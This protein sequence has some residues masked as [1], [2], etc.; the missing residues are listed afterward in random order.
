MRMD[1]RAHIIV[2]AAFLAVIV[3]PGLIQTVSE[4]RDGEPPGALDIFLQAPT[5]RNLHAYEQGLEETSLVIKRFR[6]WM[7]YVQW[8]FLA[9]AGEKVVV[10]RHGWLFYRPSVLYVI[11][12]RTGAPESDSADPLTA[13]RSFR[14]QLRARGIRL[15]VVPVPNKECVYPGMLAKRAEG[16]GVVVCEPTRRLLDQLEQ[17]GIEHVDLFEVFRRAKR[18]ENQSDPRRLYLAQDTHWS[19][20]GARVAA[21]A[22]ARRVLDGGTVNRG[23][24]AYVEHS[25]T[26]RRHGD[27]VQMLQ[28]PRIE[29]TLEPESLA[30]LRVVQSDTGTPYHDAPE[31]AILILGDSFLRIYERD[32]PGSAGFI[33][34]LARELG[35]PLTA[36]VNDGGGSTLVRQELARRPTLLMNKRLVIW[37]FAERDIRYGIEGWQVVPLDRS[38]TTPR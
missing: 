36:I 33:A 38:K 14:D 25:V 30:C 9:D 22:V 24:R 12:R 17:R 1:R 18:E 6:P 19:P 13:I 31:S 21:G 32:E 29:R 4:L 26:V 15:L 37:E 16:A 35:Q 7:Q 28:V 27:L 3:A 23:D 8:S 2:A 20:E 10:G 11:E 5:A 34:H